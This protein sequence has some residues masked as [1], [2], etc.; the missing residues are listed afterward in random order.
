MKDLLNA[1]STPSKGLEKAFRRPLKGMS[2]ASE[3]RLH[4]KGF[5]RPY[6]EVGYYQAL[7]GLVQAQEIVD[8]TPLRA[9]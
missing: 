6:K 4:F 7:N 3:K 1:S 5:L 2:K 8:V 9:F